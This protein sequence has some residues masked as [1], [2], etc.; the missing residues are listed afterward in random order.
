MK[1]I[2]LTKG[3]FAIV[4]DEHYDYLIQWRWHVSDSGYATRHTRNQKR[5]IIRMHRVINNT[6]DDLITDH[7]NGDKLDNR[8]ENL[9]T[10]NKSLNA[11]NTG[12]RKGNKSGVKGCYWEERVKSWRLQIKVNLKSIHLGYFKNIEDA[13][14]ARE[15][16]EVKYV[17]I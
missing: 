5:N 7:I 17:Q 2:P 15:Q 4:D 11:R 14:I 8:K 13:R 12:L 3:K 6:P 16:A 9:R 1:Q 10:V